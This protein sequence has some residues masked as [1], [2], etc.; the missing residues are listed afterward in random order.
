[1][2]KK[3]QLEAPLKLKVYIGTFQSRMLTKAVLRGFLKQE[4]PKIDHQ[5]CN[6]IRYKIKT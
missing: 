5:T 3:K 1:M 6:Q 2:N 4:S